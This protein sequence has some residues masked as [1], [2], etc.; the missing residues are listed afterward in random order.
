MGSVIY[1]MMG[2]PGCGKSSICEN[3]DTGIKNAFHTEKDF[4]SVLRKKMGRILSFRF[5]LV[6]KSK[7]R[8]ELIRSCKQC[9]LQGKE[10]LA[11]KKVLKLLR[12]K[13]IRAKSNEDF[14]MSEGYLQ[15]VLEIMDALKIK[16][17]SE[18]GTLYKYVINDLR[19]TQELRFILVSVPVEVSLARIQSRINRNS[20]D[21]MDAEQRRV[22][23]E[24]RFA[25]TLSLMET[26]REN[27]PEERILCLDG[28][29][30]IEENSAILSEWMNK[31]NG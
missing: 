19:N 10:D 3:V 27:V 15:A 4:Y 30:P 5:C 18:C 13:G 7:V 20:I 16:S 9:A 29:R 14:L 17:L 23:M 1:E 22:F 2:I 21:A 24:R 25:N 8:N 11:K 28:Q 12:F 31:R 26:V 6:E